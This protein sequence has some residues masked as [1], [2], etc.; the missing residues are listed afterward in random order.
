MLG[1]ARVRVQARD[2]SPNSPVVGRFD[3]VDER[4]RGLLIVESLAHRWGVDVSAE[5][6]VVWFVATVAALQ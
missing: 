2:E 1:E 3:P 6:K 5:N 4:G